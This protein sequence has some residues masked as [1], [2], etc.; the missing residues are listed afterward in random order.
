MLGVQR[1]EG[2]VIIERYP[3]IWVDAQVTSRTTGRAVEGL[4]HKDFTIS[5]NGVRQTIQAYERLPKRLLLEILV[6]PI[7]APEQARAI[8]NQLKG[9]RSSLTDYLQLEDRISVVL[10]AQRPILLQSSTANKQ[11]IDAGL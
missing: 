3:L 5:E 9:L 6:D 2:D 10:I 11:L 8:D 1:K 4:S 7:A